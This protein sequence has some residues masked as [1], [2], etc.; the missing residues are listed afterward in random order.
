[1][2]FFLLPFKNGLQQHHSRPSGFSFPFAIHNSPTMSHAVAFRFSSFQPPP[3]H[4]RSHNFVSRHVPHLCRIVS[5]LLTL[6]SQ[7]LEI[8]ATS[9]S[10]IIFIASPHLL[11]LYPIKLSF[12]GNPRQFQKA[13]PWHVLFVDVHISNGGSFPRIMQPFTE[14][15]E[16]PVTRPSFKRP[17]LQTKPPNNFKKTTCPCSSKRKRPLIQ[18]TKNERSNITVNFGS[19]QVVASNSPQRQVSCHLSIA[20]HIVIHECLPVQ[21]LF[22]CQTPNKYFLTRS[23][24]IWVGPPCSGCTHDWPFHLSE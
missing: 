16:Q 21:T 14:F 19:L 20:V 18:N 23:N 1:M 15:L 6:C 2:L 5:S 13:V 7:S 17:R 11:Q 22:I 4:C 12:S 8:R 24:V 9:K 3:N 10:S